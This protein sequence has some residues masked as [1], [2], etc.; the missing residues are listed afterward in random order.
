MANR[1]LDSGLLREHSAEPLAGYTVVVFEQASGGGLKFVNELQAGGELRRS[2]FKHYVAFAVSEAPQMWEQ[3]PIH[4]ILDDSYQ[5]DVL[6]DI[7]YAVSSATVVATRRNDDPLG[8]VVENIERRVKSSFSLYSEAAIH[9]EFRTLANTV[10]ETLLGELREH[11]I[12]YGLRVLAIDIALRLP[13]KEIDFANAARSSEMEEKKRRAEAK[14]QAERDSDAERYKQDKLRI[15]ATTQV[16]AVR[17]R[18]IVRAAEHQLAQS[19]AERQQE[20]DIDALK[21]KQKLER[22]ELE[23]QSEVMSLRGEVV[24]AQLLLD[25]DRSL[26]EST[27][28]A[29]GTALGNV[30]ANIQSSSDLAVTVDDIRSLLDGV[31]R[32]L[33]IGGSEQEKPAALLAVGARES[34]PLRRL[35]E[36]TLERADSISA[37]PEIKRTL[38]AFAL[39]LIAEAL[40]AEPDQVR[41]EHWRD[42]LTHVLLSVKPKLSQSH[43]EA[44]RTESS[45]E[46][47]RNELGVQ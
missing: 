30:A 27:L 26:N 18:D 35:L 42:E 5:F 28:K 43:L 22:A 4:I 36:R 45:I 38:H 21:R 34:A 2:F 12:S 7:R 23:G 14:R 32:R 29:I 44:W 39:H 19:D 24:R 3:L 40:S 1:T 31:T 46:H 25:R 17:Q 10:L 6:L 16:E 13:E 41:A 37:R 9:R 11:S 8:K 20:R 33:Q 15:E 47:L